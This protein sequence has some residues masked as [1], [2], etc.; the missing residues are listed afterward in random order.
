MR[1]AAFTA[2]CDACVLYPAPLRDLLLRLGGK[3]LYRARWT[4]EIDE[5]W[6]RNLLTNR[7]DLTR[8]QL[9]QL[10]GLMEAAVPDALVSG[11]E[12]FGES[13]ELPDPD[14]VHVLAA[15][16]AC[17]AQ[18]I[19]TFNLRDFPRSVLEAFSVTALH[20]DEFIMELWSLDQAGVLEA[21]ADMRR[22]LK[23][24]RFTADEFIECILR[25][26][27]PMTANALRDYSLMI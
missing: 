2:V 13:L 12:C 20:P 8:Y 3:G 5:E 19:V 25:Q 11:Y 27:L 6:K 7:K 23:R 10:S 4:R 14:D 15:A 21:A 1:E 9:D 24:S 18:V 26:G 16:I 22:S 17:N